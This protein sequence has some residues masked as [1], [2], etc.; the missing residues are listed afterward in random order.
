MFEDFFSQKF[1]TSLAK[2]GEDL[3]KFAKAFVV[4]R[5][6]DLINFSNK[7]NFLE[8]LE[9]GLLFLSL[10][11]VLSV[12]LSVFIGGEQSPSFSRLFNELM[13]RVAISSVVFVPLL[14]VYYYL[15]KDRLTFLINVM[16]FNQMLAVVL[17]GITGCVLELPEPARTDFSKLEKGYA[18]GTAAYDQICLVMEGTAHEAL[19]SRQITE[20]NAKAKSARQAFEQG[21]GEYENLMDT[22][23]KKLRLIIAQFDIIKKNWER[24]KK[25]DEDYNNTYPNIRIAQYI[26]ICGTIIIGMMAWVHIISGVFIDVK[27]KGGRIISFGA[28]LIGIT[29][30]IFFGY[31]VSTIS[32]YPD[33]KEFGVTDP[34]ELMANPTLADYE[35]AIAAVDAGRPRREGRIRAMF[36]ENSKRCPGANNY[37]LW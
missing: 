36:E 9:P 18:Q 19:L 25:I 23:A 4:F 13:W 26:F 29:A 30:A 3:I 11:F 20:A 15:Q 17:L 22:E 12:V 33:P 2:R 7:G 34:T 31:V 1:L 10:S 24:N 37:G 14:V 27:T 16:C 28:V 8:R 5:T 32:T 35:R 21:A 6:R